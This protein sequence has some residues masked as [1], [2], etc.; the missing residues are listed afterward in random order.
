MK[1]F[2]LT[3]LCFGLI[4]SFKS[5][6]DKNSEMVYVTILIQEDNTNY[7]CSTNANYKV[8]F[9]PHDSS[10]KTRDIRKKAFSKQLKGTTEFDI[11]TIEFTMMTN[12][13]VIIYEHTLSPGPSC[14][15]TAK[16]IK[17]FKIDD[18]SNVDEKLTKTK[19]VSFV[20]DR[21]LSTKILETISG[22][23]IPEPDLFRSLEHL[24]KELIIEYEKNKALTPEEKE[25]L[26]KII[27]EPTT[28]TGV[29]G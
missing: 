2:I 19:K 5:N 14:E 13:Y 6:V 15:G 29:R 24:V 18:P 27:N 23:Q 4:T 16:M 28:V 7:W 10:Y 25:K 12:E 20:K 26:K 3:I 8:L 22:P 21:I 1:Y 11:R 17:A 9:S